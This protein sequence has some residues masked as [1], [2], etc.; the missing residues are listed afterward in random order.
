MWEGETSCH[1]R[2]WHLLATNWKDWGLVPI[3]ASGISCH[4]LKLRIGD[5][6]PLQQW[7]LVTTDWKDWRQ[8]AIATV[9][10]RCHQLKR[11]GTFSRGNLMS[12]AIGCVSTSQCTCVHK[13][14]RL[15]SYL[16]GRGTDDPCCGCLGSVQSWLGEHWWSLVAEGTVQ[17]DP[18]FAIYKHKATWLL[19]VRRI[20]AIATF[21]CSDISYGHFVWNFTIK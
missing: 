6:S 17:L 3:A 9:A 19:R 5:K 13:G 7:H 16:W 11:L 8:V 4:Q 21:T 20:R 10:S 1:C 2:Q 12:A 15:V 18:H 14:R